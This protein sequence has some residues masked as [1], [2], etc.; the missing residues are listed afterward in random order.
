[1][2]C[3][4]QFLVGR[5]SLKYLR[6]RL[7]RVRMGRSIVRKRLCALAPR[8]PR[9]TVL[10]PRAPRAND[11]EATRHAGFITDQGTTWATAE[12]D[13]PTVA[14]S[15]VVAPVLFANVAAAFPAALPPDQNPVTLRLNRTAR[16]SR[17][18]P[19]LRPSRRPSL[20]V[21]TTNLYRTGSASSG[22]A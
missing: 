2:K 9:N 19:L 11:E 5:H 13:F 21:A 10:L 22:S 4:P 7:F 3:L 16:Q 12:S 15:S 18:P 8:A 14:I 20:P 1:A 17:Q 6:M